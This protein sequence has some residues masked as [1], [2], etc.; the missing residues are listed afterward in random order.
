MTDGTSP[1]AEPPAGPLLVFGPR[2]TSYDFGPGHPLTPRR[3]GPGID[4]LRAVGA[5]PGIA[6]EPATDDLLAMCHAR[7]YIAT[8]RRLG[9][10][11]EGPPGGGIE[12]A[13]GVDVHGLRGRPGRVEEGIGREGHRVRGRGEF[14]RHG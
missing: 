11:P 8:V 1:T 9:R 2:S 5:T 10:D 12:Q 13:E 3:F 7:E 14:C 6:P 4:L